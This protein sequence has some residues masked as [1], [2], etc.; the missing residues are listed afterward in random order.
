M[1]FIFDDN[2]QNSL[3]VVS[4]TATLFNSCTKAIG[5]TTLAAAISRLVQTAA[6]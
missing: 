3:C 4:F 1:T 2:L 6:E 5:L